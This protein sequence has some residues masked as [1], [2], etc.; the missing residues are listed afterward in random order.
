MR[1]RLYHFSF[2]C[3]CMLLL[4]EISCGNRA[5]LLDQAESLIEEH[6]D[7]ALNMLRQIKNPRQH[8][9]KRNYALYALLMTQAMDKCYMDLS[10]DTLMDIA[11]RYFTKTTDS[12]HAA[13]ACLYAGKV[14]QQ[15]RNPEQAIELY[16]KAK[17]Y[18]GNS[19]DYKYQFMV[20]NGLGTVYSDQWLYK[21]QLE[22][23]REACNYASLKN[24]S[25]Y[26][27]V[28]L[29]NMGFAFSGLQ[30]EDS[31]IIYQYKALQLAKAC[32]PT[33]TS[34]IYHHIS[35]IHKRKQDYSKAIEYV[36]SALLSATDRSNLYFTKG[37]IYNKMHLYDSAFCYLNKSLLSDNIYTKASTCDALAEVYK[38]VG[39]P[40]SA[41]SYMRLFNAYRDSIEDQTHTTAVIELEN[42]YHHSKLKE[43]NYL[44][45]ES[46]ISKSR[47]I[48]LILFIVSILLFFIG[49]LYAFFYNRKQKQMHGAQ[50]LLRQK[51]IEKL[52]T[53]TEFISLEKKLL[54]LR[55]AF[56][57][58]MNSIVVPK[59]HSLMYPNKSD[60]KSRIKITEEE[61]AFLVENTNIAFG[62]FTLRLLK[63]YPLLD[64][65]DIRLCCLI[66][67]Q[68]KLSD[69]ADIY[70]V[71][72]A[73]INKRR[74]RI[75]KNKMG[76]N[77]GRTLN[78]ILKSF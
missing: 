60:H 27:C 76:I 15:L 20:R 28:A 12:I 36:D 64:A 70:C 18:F 71:E 54:E 1:H 38:G 4:S 6:P 55:E 9:S 10:E 52:Q 24:D 33:A 50:Q 47:F 68:L 8:L 31:A 74:E 72:K 19:T 49:I 62:D 53:E 56:Y 16:L 66:K 58:Q 30:K 61:W 43:E 29:E 44:L 67:M 41:Y 59:L 21:D 2:F 75:R 13:K 7:S 48:Y 14:F 78:D 77:D 26:L 17:D 57:R 3:L 46:A 63:V 22:A 5:T 11:V 40:D 69:I 23:Y 34:G 65:E 42:L 39:K 37:D 32:Y 45:K 73:T 35:G 25:L 51:E